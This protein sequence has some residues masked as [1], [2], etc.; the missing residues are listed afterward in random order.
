MTT[1][2]A[3]TLSCPKCNHSF[4]VLVSLTPHKVEQPFKAVADLPQSD[5]WSTGLTLARKK[6]QN[7]G[8]R[9]QV[10]A[11]CNT[12]TNQTAK[13]IGQNRWKWVCNVCGHAPKK[14][15]SKLQP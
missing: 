6:E 11:Q 15:W 14:S 12:H 1:D 3:L 13:E 7:S 8:V 4:D 5:T 9:F 10:C 2:K